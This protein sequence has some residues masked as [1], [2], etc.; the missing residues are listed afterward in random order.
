MRRQLAAISVAHQLAGH[1]S[2][3]GDVAVRAVW[4]GTRRTHH[5]APREV[6]ALRTREIARITAGLGDGLAD[7]RDRAL[8]L[9]G[10]AGALRRS[11]L[12]AL[13]MADVDDDRTGHDAGLRL[14]IVSSKTDTDGAGDRQAAYGSSPGT[15][16]VR[17][18][19][20]WLTRSGL[21]S[22]PAFRAVH[23]HGQLG[24]RRLSARAVAEMIKRRAAAAG[25]T[26]RYQGT[27]CAPAS[28]RRATPRAFLSWASCATAAGPRSRSCV[29]T[30]R[31][32]HYGWTTPPDGLTSD[33]PAQAVSAPGPRSSPAASPTAHWRGNRMRGVAGGA[34]GVTAADSAVT[35]R[36]IC[37]DRRGP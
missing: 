11:E 25:V 26:A 21:T 24:G 31:T 15:Y 32:A 23:R 22:G 1:D 4:A 36:C 17:A 3:T 37:G 34:I 12:V 20:A 16:P 28:P 13:D 5:V 8:L 9:L 6:R 35:Y 7:T 19:R 33:R 18:W 29:A 2:P 10:F 30:S 27:P 14:R